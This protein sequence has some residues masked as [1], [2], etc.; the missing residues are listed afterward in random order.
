MYVRRKSGR[1][2]RC[3]K[4]VPVQANR[5]FCRGK[6]AHY[7]DM[8]GI[9]YGRHRDFMYKGIQMSDS[10]TWYFIYLCKT[11]GNRLI[12]GDHQII[13]L[14]LILYNILNKLGNIQNFRRFRDIDAPLFYYIG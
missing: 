6:I 10:D 13:V 7:E 11:G 8:K 5:V 4:M 12:I 3:V 1:K 14:R 2:D 9:G